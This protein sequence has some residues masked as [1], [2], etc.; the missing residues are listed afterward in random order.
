MQPL[1]PRV[2][3]GDRTAIR[4]CIARYGNLIWSLARRAGQADAEDVVQEIFV[5]LWKSA[6]RYEPSLGSETTFVA[7]IARRRLIDRRRQRQR[8]PET[9]SL[10]G[11]PSRPGSTSGSVP[12]ELGAEAALAARA[13][14]QL[15]PEQR[16]VLIL[17]TC[18]GLSHEEVAS[19]MNMPLGT[20]KAHARRGLIRVREVLGEMGALGM[21]QPMQEAR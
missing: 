21:G 4:E 20:V 12:P 5:D 10:D 8:R 19:S 14:D 7:T 11:A 16:Q 1:L 13:L 9:E 17:T 15:R 3:S 6:G 2:A 18:H